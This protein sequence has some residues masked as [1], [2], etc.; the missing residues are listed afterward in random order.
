M[1]IT[2]NPTLFNRRSALV[3]AF[4]AGLG[5]T[6]LGGRAAAEDFTRRKL[7]V[8][9]ARGAMDG[10]SVAVPFGDL[11]Y[12]SL[13]QDIAIP[14]DKVLP[15]DA[16]FGL[17]PKLK[18]L[19]SLNQ[20]GQARI[21]PAVAIPQRIR[22]HFEAQDLLETG[23]AQI[24]RR[25]HRLAK[26]HFA[27]LIA[28]PADQGIVHRRAGAAHF[29]RSGSGGKLVSGGP[30]HPQHQPRRQRPNGSLR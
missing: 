17:H 18:T 2:R 26:P 7:V 6:F 15:L 28:R 10:L 29:A 21:A 13:R 11:N 20:A 30:H 14:A 16:T 23:G 27:G 1:T 12:A 4:G 5:L 8:I 22:S 24:V 19:Y 3:S 9:V 25:L